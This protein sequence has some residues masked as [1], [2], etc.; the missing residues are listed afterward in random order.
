M[1]AGEQLKD[2]RERAG[3]SLTEMSRR[4]GK[5]DSTLNRYESGLRG[6]PDGLLETYRKVSFEILSERC[7]ASAEVAA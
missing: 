6:I 7:R 2:I 5:S 1:T 3:I 4:L